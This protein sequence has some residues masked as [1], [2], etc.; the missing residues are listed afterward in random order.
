MKTL[1]GTE[2]QIK[3]ANDIRNKF[4][5]KLNSQLVVVGSSRRAEEKNNRVNSVI[6]FINEIEESTFFINNRNI[7]NSVDFLEELAVLTGLLE[8]IE[9]V[10][11]TT[12]NW[13]SFNN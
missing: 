10:G 11:S 2:K 4:N 1:K 8:K 7:V 12:M 5:E 6:N 9:N 3:W 13:K